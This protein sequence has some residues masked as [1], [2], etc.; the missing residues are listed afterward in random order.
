MWKIKLNRG[1]PPLFYISLSQW[2]LPSVVLV[3]E[4]NSNR[5][6]FDDF[7]VSLSVIFNNFKC[8]LQCFR[9]IL[10]RIPKSRFV[11]STSKT[12]FRVPRTRFRPNFSRLKTTNKIFSVA[13]RQRKR[14]AHI[15]YD[16]MHGFLLKWKILSSQF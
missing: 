14:L 16:Q 4:I 2:Y 3:V 5:Y 13:S 9:L 15:K 11:R 8:L 1:K 6:L 12:D 10:D 7:Y